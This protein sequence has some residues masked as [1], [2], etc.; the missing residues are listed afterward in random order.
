[1]QRYL[2]QRML[3][4][5]RR[6]LGCGDFD[7]AFRTTIPSGSATRHFEIS[8]RREGAPDGWEEFSERLRAKALRILDV[9]GADG[10]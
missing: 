8:R 3:D 10:S 9:R 2:A 1:V 5:A 4:A 7:V 6:H